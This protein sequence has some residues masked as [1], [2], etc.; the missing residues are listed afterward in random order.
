MD[1]HNQLFNR[2]LLRMFLLP[3]EQ[4]L[5]SRMLDGVTLSESLCELIHCPVYS[6]VFYGILMCM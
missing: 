4:L 2:A 6:L 1:V 3:W 5:Y